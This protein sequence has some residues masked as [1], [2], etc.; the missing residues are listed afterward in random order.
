MHSIAIDG[1]YIRR[2]VESPTLHGSSDIVNSFVFSQ[3]S[4]GDGL[5]A[6]VLSIVHQLTRMLAHVSRVSANILGLMFLWNAG[7]NHCSSLEKQ[8]T[9]VAD[10]GAVDGEL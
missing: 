1:D 8:H 6:V 10:Y 9:R 7:K 4:C 5:T 2:K 3:K